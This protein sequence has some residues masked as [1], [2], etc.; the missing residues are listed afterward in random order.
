M[1]TSRLGRLWSCA[2]MTGACTA[3]FAADVAPN[4]DELNPGIQ[5]LRAEY[6]GVR[7]DMHDGRVIALFGKPMTAAASPAQ[8]VDAWWTAYGDA[9]GVEGLELQLQ[10]TSESATDKFTFYGYTQTIDGL[11]VEHSL[12]RVLVLNGDPFRVVRVGGVLAPRPEGGFAAD[13]VSAQQALESVQNRPFDE[14]RPDHHHAGPA[15]KHSDQTAGQRMTIWSQPELVVF[16]GDP[17]S[18]TVPFGGR[19]AVRAWRFVG[20]NSDLADHERLTFFVNAANGELVYVRDEVHHIDVS[21]NVQGKGSPGTLPDIASNPP[22]LMPM[23]EIRVNITGGGNALTERNGNYTIPHG[24]TAPVTLTTN[25][26]GGRWVDVNDQ[27]QTEMSL[28]QS[29]TPPGPGNFIYNDAPVAFSTAEVNAFIHTNHIHNFVRDRT[30]W[31]GMDFVCPA[32]VNINSSCNAFFNG[33]SINFYRLAGGCNNTAYTTVVAHEYGHYIVN[34]L[35]LAQGAFG[36]GFGDCCAVLLYDDPVVGRFFTTGGGSVRDYSPGIP[37]DMYPCASSCGG[38]VHCCGEILGGMWWDIREQ[39]GLRYGN[40]PG[41]ALVQQLFVDWSQVTSGGQGSNSAHPALLNEILVTDDN[42][43]DLSNGTPNYPQICTASGAHNLPC[44]PVAPIAFQFPDGI[45][46]TL[47]PGQTSSFRVNVVGL[48]AVP[49]PG[50]GTISYSINGGAFTTV[51][52]TQ[53]QPNEYTATL[54][55]LACS[56]IVKFY[57]TAGSSAGN[58]SSPTNAPTA[59]YAATALYG[60]IELVNDTMETD[61]GWTVGPGDTAT[62]GIWVR[63]DPVG[64]A[65]QPEDDHT[66]APG[67]IC[68]VTGQGAPGGAIGANDVDG[69]RTHLVSPTYNLAGQNAARIEYWRWYS[70]AEGAQPNDDVFTVQV[71][72]NNG[73]TWVTAEIVGPSGPETEPGWFFHSFLV[74]DFVTPT[75]TVRVR[76]IAADEGVGGSIVEAAV[77]DFRI[78][79]AD[80]TPPQSCPGDLDGDGVVDLDDLTVLL[81]NFGTASGADPGDGDMDNDDDVDLNDLTAMLSLFGT[82]CP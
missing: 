22:V 79:V 58:V 6:P 4:A 12:A 13:Q 77:D 20:E 5:R 62:T 49:T 17:A 44:P 73:A 60:V 24:G 3:A 38:Q 15:H 72:N 2:L 7:V 14:V 74:A 43:G 40:G 26:S 51:P 54:P 69:G 55:A 28:S 67:V 50:S 56:S 33:S 9:L 80:C 39:F 31:T 82:P 47:T 64:T 78:T 10:W 61:T 27:G 70:N 16:A 48:S 25:V 21:G 71:S 42:D 57:V 34:R 36:E 37:E 1:P 63:V 68:W 23:P 46:A 18:T 75:A 11:P 29:V 66:P 45:P 19:A 53:G 35:G 32:N 76:Y 8:A 30:S 41:L 52:M 81:S 65:A 59:T